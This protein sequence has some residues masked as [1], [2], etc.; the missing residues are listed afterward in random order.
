M[1]HTDLKIKHMYPCFIA[2]VKYGYEFWWVWIK[3]RVRVHSNDL[4]HC[5]I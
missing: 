2:V 4:A 5:L 1:Q 3:S